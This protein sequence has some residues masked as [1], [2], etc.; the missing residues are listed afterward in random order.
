M[1]EMSGAMGEL[2][3]VVWMADGDVGSGGEGSGG[4]GSSSENNRGNSFSHKLKDRWRDS[5]SEQTSPFYS[6][7][8]RLY[9]DPSSTETQFNV[10]HTF[11]IYM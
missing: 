1:V 5:Q 10:I 9:S 2:Q 11:Y 3:V 6:L 7:H 4:K 8:P